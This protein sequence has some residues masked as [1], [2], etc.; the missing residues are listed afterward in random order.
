MKSLK[1]LGYK[2]AEIAESVPLPMTL[3]LSNFMRQAARADIA[4]LLDLLGG[5]G[6]HHHRP[7]DLQPLLREGG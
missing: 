3:A 4:G 7:L 6:R 2:E 5:A 1:A